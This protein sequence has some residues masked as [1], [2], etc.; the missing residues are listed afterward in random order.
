MIG[1]GFVAPSGHP[2]TSLRCHKMPIWQEKEDAGGVKNRR[3]TGAVHGQK[4][5]EPHAM[6]G[7]K[8]ASLPRSAAVRPLFSPRP[9]TPLPMYL[10][11][12][13]TGGGSRHAPWVHHDRLCPP[14]W[15]QQPLPY[16]PHGHP[17]PG[18]RHA[19]VVVTRYTE[20]GAPVR[21]LHGGLHAVRGGGLG[22]H[23]AAS[24]THAPHTRA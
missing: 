15:S 2:S 8:S 16:R 5:V 12:L 4:S 11:T 3:R 24:R 14:A 22:S 9:R 17:T 10:T 1:M 20:I 18:K 21:A 23:T 7:V 19:C 13:G 6:L